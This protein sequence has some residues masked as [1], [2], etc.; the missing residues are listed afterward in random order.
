MVIMLS[1]TNLLIH[2]CTIVHKSVDQELRYDNKTENFLLGD[3]ITGQSSGVS[4]ILESI[5]GDSN[6]IMVLNGVSG[7]FID[8]ETLAGSTQG[9]A[10]ANGTNY[11]H[12]DE[13]GTPD[14]TKSN[15]T[16]NCRF[17]A[18]RGDII[19]QATGDIFKSLPSVT[20][21]AN[22]DPMIAE[23]VIGHSEGFERT[24]TI[25]NPKPF[26]DRNGLHHWTCELEVVE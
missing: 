16:T 22:I 3:T 14:I 21:P 2:S 4:G 25:K 15:I 18:P 6:G 20:L 24:Y 1:F 19:N 23:R 7:S 10:S 9:S 5:S 17:Y 11:D 13:Y 26:Y 8:N 12:L